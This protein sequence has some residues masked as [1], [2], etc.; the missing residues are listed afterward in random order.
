MLGCK[1]AAQTDQH[2]NNRGAGRSSVAVA[3]DACVY[4]STQ[5]PAPCHFGVQPRMLALWPCTPNEARIY[6]TNQLIHDFENLQQYFFMKVFLF[7]DRVAT[8]QT[9]GL[10]QPSRE[11]LLSLVRT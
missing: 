6:P 2:D 5:H 3:V 10:S 4:L 1:P 11:S 9:E 7:D 8:Y